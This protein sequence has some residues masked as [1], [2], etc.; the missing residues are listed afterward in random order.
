MD[1][2]CPSDLFFLKIDGAG[3]D[4]PSAIGEGISSPLPA[5][6]L[7]DGDEQVAL[8]IHFTGVTQYYNTPNYLSSHAPKHFPQLLWQKHSLSG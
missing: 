6:E 3:E 2:R 8:Q 7:Q 1:G 4:G 5:V